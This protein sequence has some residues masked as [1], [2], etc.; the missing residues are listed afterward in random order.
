MKKYVIIFVSILAVSIFAKYFIIY[1]SINNGQDGSLDL[2]NNRNYIENYAIEK[3]N[4]NPDSLKQRFAGSVKDISNEEIE[5]KT[6]NVDKPEVQSETKPA[7]STETQTKTQTKPQTEPEPS[8]QQTEISPQQQPEAKPEEKVTLLDVEKL[9]TIGN[10]SQVI[11]VTAEGYDTSYAKVTTYE[12]I[13]GKWNKV[14]DINGFIGKGGFAVEAK[15][16]LPETPRGVYT[17]GTAFG[18]YDNPGTAMN[19]IQTN[20]NDV[21]VDDSLSSFYN[22]WQKKDKNDGLWNSAENLYISAYDYAFVINYNTL[23]RIPYKG[24]AIFFHVSSGYTAGCVG[25]SSSN[26]VSILKW[27]NPSKSPLIVL[28]PKDEIENY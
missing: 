23:E 17:I 24:S 19:Y 22:T 7:S 21:W 4:V 20:N 5:I 16:S 15:E 27:L 28:T 10:S 26:M 12:K 6:N 11:I 1:K 13:N 14:L 25:V 2:A 18:R 8:K 3:S 9:K